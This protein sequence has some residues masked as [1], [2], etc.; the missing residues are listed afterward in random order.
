MLQRWERVF[1]PEPVALHARALINGE[2][3]VQFSRPVPANG[4]KVTC[5]I[6]GISYRICRDV[7]TCKAET[8]YY[9]LLIL[10]IFALVFTL[11]LLLLAN[12]TMALS[13]LKA[14]DFDHDART[15]L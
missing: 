8:L 3:S 1:L 12:C 15:H 5:M 6:L 9:L 13:R 4:L 10:I 14:F 7:Y 11:K 2:A